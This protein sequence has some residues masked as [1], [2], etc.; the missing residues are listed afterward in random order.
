MRAAVQQLPNGED[1]TFQDLELLIAL[2]P[3]FVMLIQNK[4]CAQ[5]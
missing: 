1:A 4:K 3:D 2:C 5:R